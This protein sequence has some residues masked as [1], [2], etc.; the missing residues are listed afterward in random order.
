MVRSKKI[1]IA[2]VFAAAIMVIAAC[3]DRGS[4]EVADTQGPAQTNN[5][6][7]LP[8]SYSTSPGGTLG[9]PGLLSFQTVASSQQ[10]G[11]FVTGTGSIT[12]SPDT[13]LL[14]LGVRARRD[15]VAE[16]RDEAA[17]AMAGITQVLRDNGVA[18]EDVKTQ[19]FSIHP[20]YAFRREK[21]ELDGF[22]VVN[23]VRIKVRDLD[24]VG[25]VI[26]GSVDVGGDLTQI[27]SIQFTVDD[28][29][30]FQ[31]QVREKAVQDAVTKAQQ[32][33]GLLGITLGRPISIVEGGGVTPR[34]DTG[35]RPFV[36][37]AAIAPPTSVSPGELE[38]RLNVNIVFAI[39]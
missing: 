20:V 24:K 28:L 25:A 15:T 6:T 32:M 34:F 7:L 14:T 17:R 21:Q 12:V 26:D 33:A 30:P 9:E 3:T 10:I 16:A 27:Q 39:E 38:L 8:P 22:E 19:S 37:I 23:I 13:A 18:E 1:L 31:T 5:S 11:I 35:I 36:E 4:S 29:S 2:L